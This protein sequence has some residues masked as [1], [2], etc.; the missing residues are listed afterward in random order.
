MTEQQKLYA[1]LKCNKI[2]TEILCLCGGESF[3][4]I[5]WTI[6][7]DE[8]IKSLEEKPSIGNED[9]F[10]KIDAEL[11]NI[12]HLI[13]KQS[14]WIF[15]RDNKIESLNN[16]IK[17]LEENKDFPLAMNQALTDIDILRNKI[18]KLESK[19]K[20][21]FE[22]ELEETFAKHCVNK[23]DHI[24]GW[25]DLQGIFFQHNHPLRQSEY[26]AWLTTEPVP[27]AF[28]FCPDCGEKIND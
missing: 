7:P 26:D 2:S 4:F 3:S 24:I 5:E 16:R 15:E 22:N 23:C 28:A 6:K 21:Q 17:S 27:N 20:I 10:D 25:N 18:I 12:H 8:K 1:C 19:E 14:K 13:I 11:E 9:V